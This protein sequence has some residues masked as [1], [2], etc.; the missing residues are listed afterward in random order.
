MEKKEPKKKR[1]TTKI[2][3]NVSAFAVL[4]IAISSFGLSYNAIYETALDFGMKNWMAVIMPFIIDG[5]IF[6]FALAILVTNLRSERAFYYWVLLFSASAISVAINIYHAPFG[7]LQRA[8]YTI[9]PLA[10]AF[11]FHAVMRMVKY[12]MNREK[13]LLSIAALQ[14]WADGLQSE[15][16]LHNGNIAKKELQKEKLQEVNKELQADNR[17]LRSEIKALQKEKDELQVAKPKGRKVATKKA[18]RLLE[19]LKFVAD[20]NAISQSLIAT[21]L[22]VNASTITRDMKHLIEVGKLQNN[23]NGVEVVG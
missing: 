4:L 18:E 14:D 12:A 19:I 16:E 2:M 20:D 22:G 7:F 3:F 15:I 21:K 11:S 5:S 13:I 9:P 8:F 6:V 1:D 17:A 23:G 10:L